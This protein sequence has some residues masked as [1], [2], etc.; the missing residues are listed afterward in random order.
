MRFKLSAT[1]LFFASIILSFANP[2]GMPDEPID[3]TVQPI[4]SCSPKNTTDPNVRNVQ[5]EISNALNI[6]GKIDHTELAITDKDFKRSWSI[7][8]PQTQ[9]TIKNDL[10]NF[11]SKLTKST[12]I[13]AAFDEA[14]R[15]GQQVYNPTNDGA[16]IKFYK[17]SDQKTYTIIIDVKLDSEKYSDAI[18]LYSS[19]YECTLPNEKKPYT[20]AISKTP[21][22]IECDS[23]QFS[24]TIDV[25]L[26]EGPPI[27]NLV[28][29]TFFSPAGTSNATGTLI[30]FW[31]SP[32]PK[33]SYRIDF[34]NDV[35]VDTWFK[36]GTISI[37]SIQYENHNDTKSRV[38]AD[39][40]IVFD[41]LSNGNNFYL[42]C[43]FVGFFD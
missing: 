38:I 40:K 29:I 17:G 25:D 26:I 21:K 4:I 31:G 24:I 42:T 22:K 18:K 8:L 1:I 28:S 11:Y 36:E 37:H 19:D 12:F 9:P 13:Y 15:S 3:D 20:E 5:Y 27:Q 7:K 23:D 35:Q 14:L 6:D 39:G 10:F 30:T 43:E 34:T 2:D 33:V 32:N 16:Y 41:P